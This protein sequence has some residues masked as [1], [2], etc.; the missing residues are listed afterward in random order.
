[1]RVA[2]ERDER[3]PD[4]LALLQEGLDV[5]ELTPSE[6]LSQN[7]IDAARLA[8]RE[9]CGTSTELNVQCQAHYTWPASFV[10][11]RAYLDQ[12]T[13][14][15]ALPQ[16]RASAINAAMQEVENSTGATRRTAVT[17]LNALA[18]Q[19]AKDSASAPALQAKRM[20]D[21]ASTIQKRNGELK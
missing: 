3:G 12:L 6:Y 14:D 21:C 17:K 9:G 19:L 7:E 4:A 20:R 16:E 8:V 5:F 11:A 15:N 1:M 18:D 10:V 13:R 2:D